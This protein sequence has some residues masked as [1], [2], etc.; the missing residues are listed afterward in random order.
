MLRSA[1]KISGFKI[2]ASDGEVGK[3]DHL[4]FDDQD[5]VVRHVAVKTGNWLFGKTVLL[6][7]GLIRDIRWEAREFAVPLTMSQIEKSPD[8]D[9]DEPVS[10]ML[11]SKIYDHYQLPYYW[12][13]TSAWGM[14]TYLGTMGGPTALIRP[15]HSQ[16][17]ELQK[18]T[19]PPL[20]ES[21]LHLRSS[22]EVFG[23]RVHAPE[24][25]FGHV[26]D[27]VLDTTTWAIRY[28]A[29]D[30]RG[31]V[32]RHSILLP[33][34]CVESVSWD[35]QRIHVSRSEEDIAS[36]PVFHE[37]RFLDRETEE[38]VFEYFGQHPYWDA[39]RPNGQSAVR[40]V[41]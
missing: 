26:S 40:K 5:W 7:P 12:G 6:P 29:V 19:Q 14:S 28:V 23:Y 1:K 2:M 32:R 24:G 9:S 20:R 10:R 31:I 17:S 15:V 38:K 35:E 4:L 25:S 16:P 37:N 36:A 11:E 33:R 41:V 39:N 8:V 30:V 21:E 22:T 18:E 27:F 34:E 13:M 3:V